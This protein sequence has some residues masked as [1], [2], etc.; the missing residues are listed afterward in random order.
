[1]P[2]KRRHMKPVKL[3]K[4]YEQLVEQLDP[5]GWICMGSAIKRSYERLVAGRQKRFGPYYSWTRKI[6]DKTETTALT[7]Q[8][9]DLI[10]L[11]IGRNQRIEKSL[12][13]LRQISLSFILATTPCVAKRMRQRQPQT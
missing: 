9:F 10:R 8:Q 7:K 5:N 2:V 6:N 11:A 4:R 12:T 13:Q 3:K 1:M